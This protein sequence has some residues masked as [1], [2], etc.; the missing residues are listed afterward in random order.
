[1]AHQDLL[2]TDSFLAAAERALDA[3]SASE[4]L[5]QFLPDPPSKDVDDAVLGPQSTGR[6]AELFS[7]STPPPRSTGLLC[8]RNSWTKF[9]D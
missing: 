8:S 5:K 7:Q 1:M 4:A 6:T 3:N 2:T 9:P